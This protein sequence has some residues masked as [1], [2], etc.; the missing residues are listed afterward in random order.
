MQTGALHAR[1][2]PSAAF[3]RRFLLFMAVPCPLALRKAGAG[4]LHDL[5]VR[6]GVSYGPDRG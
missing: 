4:G 3:R 5:L 1:G 6:A 2:L